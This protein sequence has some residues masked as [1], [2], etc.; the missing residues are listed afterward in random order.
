M[1]T[2]AA[3]WRSARVW[4]TLLGNVNLPKTGKL[5]LTGFYDS[6]LSCKTIML[7]DHRTLAE[8]TTGLLELIKGEEK[9]CFG[10]T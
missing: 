4:R 10:D 9:C 8:H 2:S 3:S 7:M 1:K 6:S 5:L